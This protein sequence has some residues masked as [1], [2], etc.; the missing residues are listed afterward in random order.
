MRGS[1][2]GRQGHKTEGTRNR[3]AGPRFR[4]RLPS[5]NHGP[6]FGPAK[7]GNVTIIVTC[8]APNRVSVGGDKM[9]KGKTAE[10]TSSIS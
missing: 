5:I 3:H 10:T 1:T 7:K 8:F 2:L 6:R 9:I 4:G